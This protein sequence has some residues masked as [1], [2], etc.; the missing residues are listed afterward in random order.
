MNI[1]ESPIS[2]SIIYFEIAQLRNLDARGTPV[3][4]RLHASEA[5]NQGAHVLDPKV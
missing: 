1:D 2:T 4:V 3:G 5:K